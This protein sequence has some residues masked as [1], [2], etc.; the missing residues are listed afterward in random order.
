[1][2]VAHPVEARCY[3][4]AVAW[5]LV[6]LFH[7]QREL[8]ARLVEEHCYQEEVGRRSVWRCSC[9]ASREEV[10]R[11]RVQA[12]AAARVVVAFSQK[13][14]QAVAHWLT[15]QVQWGLVR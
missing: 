11:P 3:R 7:R 10:P 5:C 13:Y 4:E 1:M 2:E 12:A 14:R 9:Q 15:L 6:V 8:A